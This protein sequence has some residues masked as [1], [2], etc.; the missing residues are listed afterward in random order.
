MG[1][2]SHD[3]PAHARDRQADAPAR[4]E[5]YAAALAGARQAAEALR[6][7]RVEDGDDA[8][9]RSAA[10]RG[11]VTNAERQADILVG[12]LVSLGPIYLAPL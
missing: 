7:M 12:E 9:E 8:A 5:A 1:A 6:R 2:D 4:A 11:R 10:D 3:A